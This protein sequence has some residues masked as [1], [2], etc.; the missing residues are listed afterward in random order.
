M[1]L[2]ANLGAELVERGIKRRIGLFGTP[3]AYSF[4]TPADWIIG[5]ST[6]FR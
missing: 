6:C 4:P 5:R 2:T 1:Q 3:S